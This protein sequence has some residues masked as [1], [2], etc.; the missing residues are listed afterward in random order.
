MKL[1]PTT[2]EELQERVREGGRLLPRGGG[3]KPAL[4]SPNDGS[5]AVE[6]VGLSS[7]IE[8]EPSEFTFTA[9]AGTRLSDIAPLLAEN[10]QYLPFDPLFVE[11]GATL[12]G[13]LAAGLS[14][15]GRY[16]YGGLRDF[17]LG[18]KYLNGAGEIVRAGG[19]VVK[20]AAG[21]D[22]QKLMVG[23]LGSLGVLV[24]LTFKV[25]PRP[26][27]TLTLRLACDDLEGALQTQFKLFPCPLDIDAL[28]LEISPSEAV[29]W[30]RLAGYG[31]VLPKRL[32]RLRELVGG[33]EVFE[34][35][36]EERIWHGVREMKWV[37][38]GW[39]L[40][41]APIT[42][43]RIETLEQ[44][45]ERAFEE[46]EIRRRY[47]CG[48]QITWLAFPGSLEKMDDVLGEQSLPGLVVF[49][50]PGKRRLGKASG[51]SFYRRIKQA[52]DPDQRFVEV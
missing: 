20:N 12:G 23:S 25:L 48:G 28:D 24:E 45:L 33:G 40:V 19:K 29:L 46:V 8:Y 52:L 17:I 32:S 18:V 9:L 44:G 27:K 30:V 3:T 51:A 42:P 43:G 21:F 13:S 7:L 38:D 22:I 39:S 14:G 4:S 35:Q 1:A 50:P 49:G 31:G 6:V 26:E 34:A 36:D 47:S 37:P 10:G 5:D 15:P 41:K 11:R 16:H 2:I